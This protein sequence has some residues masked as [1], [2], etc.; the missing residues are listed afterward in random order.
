MPL[1]PGKSRAVISSNIRK[2]V[3]AGKKPAQAVAIALRSAGKPRRRTL[4]DFMK[5]GNDA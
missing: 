5:D 3:A 1:K 2:E 4:S